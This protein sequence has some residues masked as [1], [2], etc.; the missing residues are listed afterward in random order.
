MLLTGAPP[1]VFSVDTNYLDCS[2]YLI[3]SF[4]V[5]KGYLPSDL[6][7]AILSSCLSIFFLKGR[8]YGPSLQAPFKLTT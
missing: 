1:K 4:S 8:R 2:S 5:R 7:N 3:T 6:R